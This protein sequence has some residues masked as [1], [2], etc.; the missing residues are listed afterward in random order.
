[1][2]KMDGDYTDHQVKE[3]I[4][5]DDYFELT[6]YSFSSIVLVLLIQLACGQN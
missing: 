2:T 1:M 5:A 4:H 3:V 6:L